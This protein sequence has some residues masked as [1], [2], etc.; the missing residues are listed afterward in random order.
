MAAGQRRGEGPAAADLIL[1]KE[2]RQLIVPDSKAGL[3]V[4][5]PLES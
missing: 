4:W 2:N 5:V 3:L 1:D